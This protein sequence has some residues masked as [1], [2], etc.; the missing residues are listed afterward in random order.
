MLF[1]LAADYSNQIASLQLLIL[2]LSTILHIVF[3]GAVARD[4]GE[5]TKVGQ[6][7]LLVSGIT[8]AF[9]TLIGGVFVAVV[10]WVMHHS[11]L[12]RN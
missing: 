1:N 11:K 9:A 5:L 12:T 10:Y 3:A 2:F 7:T 6:K 8:W 4:T